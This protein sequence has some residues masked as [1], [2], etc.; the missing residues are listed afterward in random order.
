M[1]ANYD[2]S[3]TCYGCGGQGAVNPDAGSS[4]VANPGRGGVVVVRFYTP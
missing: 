3:A 4:V 2:S 1:V